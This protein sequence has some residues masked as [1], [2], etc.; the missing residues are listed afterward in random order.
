MT[1]PVVIGAV[2][3]LLVIGGGTAAYVATKDSDDSSS[4]SKG[5]QSTSEQNSFAPTSTDGLEFTA[6]ISTQGGATTGEA[7][8]EHDDKGVTRYVA[9]QGGQQIEFVY[10]SDT[11]YSCNAGKCI[12]FPITQSSNSS[13]NPSDFTYDET[14]ISGYR[15]GASYKGQKSCPSGTCDVWSVGVTGAT[16][17]IYVDSGT[18]R[19]TQVE[20]AQSGSTAKIVYD[21]K[22][23]TISIPANAQTL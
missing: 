18:K 1:R 22:D 17:T 12:K 13:F 16:S 19:I 4:Q 8:L 5:G 6:T 9:T 7:I 2:V 11:Y 10:T 20:T 21:Y 14:K 23:V 15:G 3:A